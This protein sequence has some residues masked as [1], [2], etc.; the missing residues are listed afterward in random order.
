MGWKGCGVERSQAEETAISALG[1]L[2]GDEDALASFLGAAG[3]A[4]EDLRARA[5]SPEFLGFVMDFLLGDETLLFAFCDARGLPY[6]TPMRARAA[7]PGGDAP[8][9]T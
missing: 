9:W 4:P 7:L 1:W 8:D 2:A 5:K 3:A 6:D